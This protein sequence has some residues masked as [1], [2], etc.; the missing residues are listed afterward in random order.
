MLRKRPPGVLWVWELIAKYFASTF[1]SL[2]MY[3]CGV[4]GYYRTLIY[5]VW[6]KT[7]LMSL[8]KYVSYHK[9]GEMQFWLY[10]DTENLV[11]WVRMSVPW[12]GA[13]GKQGSPFWTISF[14]KYLQKEV[15]NCNLQSICYMFANAKSEKYF[16]QNSAMCVVVVWVWY[17]IFGRKAA[18]LYVQ[19]VVG[20][21]D[22]SLLLGDL[23]Y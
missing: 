23:C 21:F 12:L 1:L 19:W 10:D 18:H 20:K 4:C 9:T 11:A 14:A 2:R 3:Y 5:F 7:F 15:L 6:F 13:K 17:Q 22:I 8:V 16:H